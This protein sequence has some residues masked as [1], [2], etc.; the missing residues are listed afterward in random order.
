M[1]I[2]SIKRFGAAIF[3]V[4]I[5]VLAGATRVGSVTVEVDDDDA[6]PGSTPAPS[7]SQPAKNPS[8]ALSEEAENKAARVRISQKIGFYYFLKAGFTVLDDSR[9]S[10]VGRVL[11]AGREKKLFITSDKTFVELTSGQEGIKIGDLLVVYRMMNKVEEARSGFSGY[12]IRNLAVV[13]VLEVEKG[14]CLVETKQ[15][16]YSYKAGDKVR[17][18]E[19]EIKRWKQAQVKKVLPD[20]PVKCFV[21]MADGSVKSASQTEFIVL[22]AGSKKGVVEGQQ[23]Q[24]KDDIFLGGETVHESRGVAQVFYAGADCSMAQIVYSQDPIKTGLE[25]FY[26]P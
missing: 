19:D 11:G 7:V 13:K 8:E 1:F 25:A 4:S 20:H 14:H 12:W 18:Y 26:Q 9:V 16:F 17:L 23:F 22:T 3:M 15:S 2:D 5:F 10:S 24:I 21:A 6:A